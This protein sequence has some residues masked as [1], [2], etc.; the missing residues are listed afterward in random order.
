[1]AAVKPGTAL[2]RAQDDAHTIRD[3]V[4]TQDQIIG[5]RCA[6]HT[7]LLTAVAGLIDI[8]RNHPGVG[9]FAEHVLAGM[10]ADLDD[11]RDTP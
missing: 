9:L 10:V 11:D 7:A 2:A 6:E 8:A 3:W 4:A 5:V 1:M